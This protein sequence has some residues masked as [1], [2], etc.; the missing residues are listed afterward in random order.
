MEWSQYKQLFMSLS[1][2]Q[3]CCL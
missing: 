1:I 3:N 2:F